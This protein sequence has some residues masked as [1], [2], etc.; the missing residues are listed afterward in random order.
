MHTN[1][2]L[3]T[4]RDATLILRDSHST[5]L[6]VRLVGLYKNQYLLASFMGKADNL[7]NAKANREYL[8]QVKNE[9]VVHVFNASVKKVET[10]SFPVVHLSLN[11]EL[12][13]TKRKSPRVIGDNSKLKLS[14]LKGD[15]LVA[16]AMAD[17]SVSGARLIANQRVGN[18]GDAFVIEVESPR[19]NE[20]YK[21]SCKIRHLRTEID[22]ESRSRI[23]FHHGVEFIDVGDEMKYF[24]EQFVR[25]TLH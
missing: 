3:L 24:L 17:I 5:R 6:N 13:N 7:K 21:V 14:L 16:V 20:C 4:G 9:N 25:E 2:E 18:I 11:Q 8:V 15:D 22:K 1:I 12:L 10:G 19:S 23:V